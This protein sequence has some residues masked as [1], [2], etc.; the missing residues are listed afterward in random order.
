MDIKQDITER[1]DQWARLGHPAMLDRFILRNGKV[2]TP[3]KRI[4]HKRTPKECFA[5]ATRYVLKNGGTYVEG[6]VIGNKLPIPIHHAWVT[7]DGTDAM[8][9]TLD[10]ENY[11]YMGVEFD[12]DTLRKQTARNGYFG[13]LDNGLGFNTR[14]MFGRDPELE[15]ICK[16]V[17]PDQKLKQLMERA[18]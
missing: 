13:L 3:T 7:L 10:A 1:V 17:K 8:D 6:Y 18:K 15:A 16:A 12:T 4:G 11:Q 2:Y 14:L 9:I 5:N